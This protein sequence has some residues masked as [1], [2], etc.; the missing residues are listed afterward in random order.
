MSHK[1]IIAKILANR[2]RPLL[3]KLISP[4]QAG[5][6]PGRLIQENTILVHEII[7]SMKKKQGHGGLMAFKLDIEKTHDKVEW[8]YLMM[9]LKCF[10]FSSHWIQLI[11]QCIS[12]ISYSI[13]LNGS[14]YGF[15]HPQRGLGPGDPLS[16][17]L[18]IICVEPL[19]LLFNQLERNRGIHGIR[20]CRGAPLSPISYLQMT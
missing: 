16:P 3:S 20:I 4:M 1:K 9:A 6:V 18:F 12:T 2:L 15:F 13:L 5:F 19:S 11:S 14:P 17:F 10:D 7:H 8:S